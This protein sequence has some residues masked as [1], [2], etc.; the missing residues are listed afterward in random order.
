MSYSTFHSPGW[1]YTHQTPV[2]DNKY[3][4]RVTG[5]IKTATGHEEFLGPPAVDIIIRSQHEETVQ[6]AF[7]AERSVPMAAMLYHIMMMMI[8]ERKLELDSI[9]ATKYTIRVILS[10]ELSVEEFKE[11]A[12]EMALGDA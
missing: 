1:H 11:I 10:H 2:I 6:C 8:K 5:E 7:R 12:K 4:D 3:I 9:I